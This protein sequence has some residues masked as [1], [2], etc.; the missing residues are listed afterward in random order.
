[1]IRPYD[2][3]DKEK[4]VEIFLLNVPKYFASKER[5]DYEDY[6]DKYGETYFTIEHNGQIAGGTG[7]YINNEKKS[8]NITWIFFHPE[9][10]G[11][12]LGR[13]AVEY[14]LSAFRTFPGV[15]RSIVNTSQ[16]AFKFF[17]KLGYELKRTEK[18]YWAEGLDLFEMEKRL[19]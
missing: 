7:Y 15:D 2:I 18:D 8:G 6:L 16:F 9:Y 12:G 10:Q 17:E 14:C 11:S 13:K 1:M 3:R 4:L 5:Y 19:I